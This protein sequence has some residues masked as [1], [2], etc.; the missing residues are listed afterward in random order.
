MLLFDIEKVGMFF[1]IFFSSKNVLHSKNVF[2]FTFYYTV[3]TANKGQLIFSEN[4][5]N[6][7]NLVI[8][9]FAI[10]EK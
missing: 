8:P 1:E 2:F 9:L 7:G 3:G 6:K 5:S 10:F 4:G